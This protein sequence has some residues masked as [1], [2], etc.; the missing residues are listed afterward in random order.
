MTEIDSMLRDAGEGAGCDCLCRASACLVART[1]EIGD[2]DGMKA[3][4]N[5]RGTLGGRGR[6]GT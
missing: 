1:R 2:D 6:P 4:G 3:S 5:E